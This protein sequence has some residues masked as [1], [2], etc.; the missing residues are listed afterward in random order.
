MTE[1]L[2]DFVCG[3]PDNHANDV[4]RI[5]YIETKQIIKSRGLIWLNLKYGYWK[6]S[7]NNIQCQ[8]NE[9]ISNTEAAWLGQK[10]SKKSVLSFIC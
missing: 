9:D 10:Q 8:D 3:Y 1:E 7:K 2:L 6:K 4:Y 5:F